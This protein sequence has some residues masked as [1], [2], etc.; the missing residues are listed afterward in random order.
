VTGALSGRKAVLPGTSIEQLDAVDQAR[1]RLGEGGGGIDR[2]DPLG[3][4]RGDPLPVLHRLGLGVLDRAGGHHHHDRG[5]EALQLTP[6]DVGW[7]EAGVAGDVDAAGDRDHLRDPEA[8]HPR[9][10][11][12][13]QRDHPRTRRARERRPHRRQPALQFPPQLVRVLL[14]ARC[15]TQANDLFEYLAE[16]C[17]SH[18]LLNIASI[19]KAA[20]RP[21][22]FQSPE[23]PTTSQPE[24]PGQIADEHPPARPPAAVDRHQWL[25]R[26]G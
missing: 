7:A 14:H 16:R 19:E 18:Y 11:Q 20:E 2:E 21:A 23:W 6:A 4:E 17:D 24:V 1:A 3:A 8:G 12:P 13:L 5:V 25:F 26:R 15:L 9:R 10:V 22:I